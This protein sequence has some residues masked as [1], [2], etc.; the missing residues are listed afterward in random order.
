M[1][2]SQHTILVWGIDPGNSDDRIYPP[3]LEWGF[4]GGASLS[5]GFLETSELGFVYFPLSY[6]QGIIPLC[7]PLIKEES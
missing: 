5:Q 2:P 4:Q 7:K 3:T 6:L 1:L